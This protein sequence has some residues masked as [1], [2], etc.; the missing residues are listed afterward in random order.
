MSKR[1]CAI[2]LA[3]FIALFF[4][5]PGA[6]AQKKVTVAVLPFNV[7]SAENIEYVKQGVWDMLISRLS[8]NEGVTVASKEQVMETIQA[9]KI[10]DLTLP[11]VYAVGK[12]LNCD[13]A[14]WGSITKIGNSVSIDGKLLDIAAYTHPVG[15][16]SQTQGMDE[17]IGKINELAKKI[18][19]YISQSKP[20]TPALSVPTTGTPTAPPVPRAE[21]SKEDKILSTMRKAKRATLTGAINP[22]FISGVM[23]RD[24]KTFWMSQKYP[25]EFR[26]IDIGDVNGDGLNEIVAIDRNSVYIF[27]KTGNEMR[28]LQKLQG[29]ATDN[30]L[31][32]DVY[33]LTGNKAY[34]II[35]TNVFTSR[36]PNMYQHV[37]QSS[38][39]SYKDGKWQK[40]ADNLPWI[41][42][43]INNS[44]TVRLL[45]QELSASATAPTGIS[46]P[47]D[48][49]IYEMV[50]R[51]GKVAEG[52]KMKI[53]KGLCIYGLTI[54][55]LGEGKDKIIALNK[56]D[57]LLVMEETDRDMSKIEA[58][59]GGKEILFK[60]EDVFGGSNLFLPMY[61][62]DDLGDDYTE[63]NYYL[64]PR[65]ITYDLSKTGKREIFIAK[66]DAPSGRL[67]KNVKIFTSTEF[68]CLLWDS[69]GLEENWRTKKL[70]GYAADYQI[71]DI[72]NDGEDEIVIALVASS[73]S[74]VAQ[75]SVIVS[76]KLRASE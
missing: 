72:D 51:N 57:H 3:F 52:R 16:L 75:N 50:W 56:Y 48:S 9:L 14:V 39:I 11:N 63:F 4:F 53:P 17:V 62:Q 20:S 24:K 61:G 67:L 36:G 68:Y 42:R 55:N 44:G 64:N 1:R 46:G 21:G 49:P 34:D 31:G 71:K 69:I 2:T 41:F 65:I 45:G 73:A 12:K 15:L 66:N 74:L 76:Y 25:T 35:V 18:N 26:G 6:F 19:D 28:L 23:P 30:Y 5:T 8:T 27:Q 70:S 47:F 60:S 32:V 40:I 33:P 7:N 10:K 22:D 38:V 29:K 59:F 54:D 43:A 37:V 13:F 58:L